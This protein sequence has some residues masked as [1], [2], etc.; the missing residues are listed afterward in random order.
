[1]KSVLKSINERVISTSLFSSQRKESLLPI[2]AAGG[3]IRHSW[4]CS[5][6]TT[7]PALS[8]NY[9]PLVFPCK[10]YF[11]KDTTVEFYKDN[12]IPHIRP[13]QSYHK[14]PPL[15]RYLLTPLF[16]MKPCSELLGSIYSCNL[17]EPT[18]KNVLASWLHLPQSAII[19]CSHM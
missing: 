6:N 18:S 3:S 11:Y 2:S 8:S 4:P 9:L 17:V 16:R 5:C 15:H 19:P 14:L 12:T 7:I 13:T 10:M 1:M